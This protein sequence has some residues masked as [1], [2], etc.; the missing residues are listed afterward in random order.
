MK[1]RIYKRSRWILLAL[2]LLLAGSFLWGCEEAH[3]ALAAEET[4][5]FQ[6]MTVDEKERV[7]EGLKVE[8]SV[9]NTIRVNGGSYSLNEGLWYDRGVIVYGNTAAINAAVQTTGSSNYKDGMYRYLGY[10]VHGGLYGNDD[11]PRDSDSGTS[12]W[13][14]DWLTTSEIRSDTTARNYVGNFAM[15]ADFETDAKFATAETFLEENPAW[16]AAGFDADYILSHF[17]FNAVVTESGLTQGQFVGVHQSRYDN[18]LYYQTFSLSVEMRQYVVPPEEPEVTEPIPPPEEPEESVGAACALGLPAFTYEGHPA[19]AEDLSTFTVDGELYS[20]R[21][22]YEEN[23]ADNRFSIVEGGPNTLSRLSTTRAEATFSLAG[24]YHVE[25][26]VTPD[27]ASSLYDTKPIEVRSTPT[28]L[29]S[30]TGARKQNRKQVLNLQVATH[31]DYPLTEFWVELFNQETG[32][33]ATLVHNLGAK[34]NTLQNSTTIKTRPIEGLNSNAFFQNCKLEFLTKNLIASDYRYTVYVKDSRGHE[35]RVEV[36]FSVAPDQSPSPMI[37]MESYFL[38]GTSS[39]QAEILLEDATTTDG[40]QV[41]GTWYYREKEEESWQ[42]ATSRDDFLDYSFG[43]GKKVGFTKEGVGLFSVRL[44]VKELWTEETLPEYV[45]PE[46]HLTGTSIAQGEVI[47]VAPIVSLS[48]IPQ[49]SAE[50]LLLAGGESEFT[51]L[52]DNKA[53]LQQTLQSNGVD[54]EITVEKLTPKANS[55]GSKPATGIFSVN[56]PFGYNGGGTFYESGNFIVDEERLYKIDATWAGASQTY[57]P[58]SPYTISCFEAVSGRTLWTYAFSSTMLSVP[59]LGPYL[60]QDDSGQYL[61]FV[62]SGKTLVLNKDTGSFLALLNTTVGSQNFVRENSIYTV[63][64]DGIYSISTITGREKQVFQGT[65]NGVAKKLL[66]KIH[67]VTADGL[68][69]FRGV[70]DPATE[71]VHLERLLG[72]ESDDGRSTYELA[73]IDPSGRLVVTRLTPSAS[74]YTKGVRV[75]DSENELLFQTSMTDTFSSKFT[76]TPIYDEGGSCNYIAYTWESRGSSSYM[77]SAKVFG[78]SNSYVGETYVTDSNGYPTVASQVIFSKERSGKVYVATGAYWTWILYTNS[79]GNGPTHGYPERTRCFVFD[80][81]ANTASTGNL[82]DLGIPTVTLE[83]GRSSETLTA[84]QTGNNHAGLTYGSETTL[85]TWNQTLEDTLERYTR[86]NFSGEKD[87]NAVVIYD[88]TNPAEQYTETLIDSLRTDIEANQGRLLLADA[89]SIETGEL[90]DAILDMGEEGRNALGIAIEKGNTGTI[91]KTFRLAPNTTYYYEYELKNSTDSAAEEEVEDLLTVSFG[92]NSVLGDSLLKPAGFRVTDVY[93]EDFNDSDLESFFLLK[94]TRIA[95]GQ[96]W[97]ANVYNRQGKNWKNYYFADSS[98]LRFTVPAGKR[99][100]LSFDWNILMSGEQAWMANF[101]QVNGDEWQAFVPRTGIGHYTHPIL[102]PP[103]ENTLSFFASAYGGKITE[104]KTWIDNLRVDL[105]EST[106]LDNS[107]GTMDGEMSTGS[108]QKSKG[109]LYVTGSFQTPPPVVAYR[110]Q[111]DMELLSGPIGSVP[112]TSW[113]STEAGCKRVQFNVPTGKTATYTLLST[114]SSPRYY[115]ETYY[116]STY[117]WNGYSWT[118]YSGNRYS[119]SAMY[120]V[121]TDYRIRFPNLTGTSSFTQNSATYRGAYG[122]FSWIT[123]AVSGQTNSLIDQNRFFLDGGDLFVE[124]H[125]FQNQGEVSLRFPEGKHL[126]I[127]LKLYSIQNGSKVYV[128]DETFSEASDLLE[129][130]SDQ[131][132]LAI[133]RDVAPEEE[134][135][136]LVYQKGE[137]IHYG[138]Q[139]YDYESDPSKRQYWRYTHLPMNDGPNPEVAVILDEEG[140]PLSTPGTVLDHPIQ[141]FY[142]DGK[143]ILDHWQQDNTTRP[144]I[145]AGNPLYDKLSNVETIAFYVGGGASAP[146]VESIRTK[147]ITVKEGDLYSLFIK[148]DD[149]EKEELRLSTELYRDGKLIISNRTTGI[150]AD[151]KGGYP[152][153]EIGKIPTA[154]AGRYEVVCTVRD[155]SGAG[156]GTY[157]FLVTSLGTITGSVYHTAQWEENRK[158]YNLAFFGEEFNQSV[159][160]NEYLFMPT[161]RKRGTNVFWSGERFLLKAVVGGNP[162]SVTVEIP[163]FSSYRTTLFDTGETNASGELIF[164]GELWDRTMLNRWG[165]EE[166]KEVIVR[167]KAHYP[168]DTVMTVDVPLIL[169]SRT[170]YW[171]LH[172]LW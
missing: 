156:M 99:A 162:D 123:A 14:K 30:L 161:P 152:P 88:T 117:S 74:S 70:F 68:T 130:N 137:A 119:Q 37:L 73:G 104:S 59:D 75:Y 8:G 150:K 11:F 128:T 121:P 109:N 95:D 165:S 146:W 170:D 85:L 168:G 163:E 101:L 154:T 167:F 145:P 126:L 125:S 120:N 35:D 2:T 92:I 26:R 108:I 140:L 24:Q 41:E 138:I 134:E 151:A 78:I 4:K 28:I 147:P 136:S 13:L 124:N 164:S 49:L 129:W 16:T 133:V 93:I 15:N 42:P 46:E 91:T 144:S 169:D 12:P 115:R 40:D 113:T 52:N 135:K 122:D 106:T 83:Y 1:D 80:P 48:T 112:Y 97:G 159:T 57:Y 111:K 153:T 148:V 33:S 76:V 81:V 139:Y 86:K 45:T 54:A 155:D 53:L 69:L 77:V 23:L 19:L 160:H 44:D 36:D 62:A 51:L 29:H 114:S 21:R 127:G 20:A 66:G 141:R 96:Y 55:S 84:V 116:G 110:A 158:R 56:T 132:Q 25:L 102:L 9:P 166:P 58:Q 67:F 157:R 18:R 65:I 34:T 79:Y 118:S 100:A 142:I 43:T 7:L 107:G 64:G 131:A 31:P 17:Y 103:G 22:A 63:K 87:I 172:R 50:I 47:N 10:D 3:A 72:N 38:R 94:E 39:N 61:F 82:G 5:T 98:S 6:E 149:T 71:K 27:G 89:A 105:V 171:L 143:Y 32:E 60:A 90:G